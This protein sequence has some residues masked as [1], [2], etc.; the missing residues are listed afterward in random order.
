MKASI[1]IVIALFCLT[2][3]AAPAPWFM[4][5]SKLDGK[6]FCAQ[7]KPGEGWEKASGPYQDARCQRPGIPGR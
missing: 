7:T 4:W 1:T 3:L 2:V 5:R 6:A